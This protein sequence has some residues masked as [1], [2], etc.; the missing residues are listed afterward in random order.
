MTTCV[1]YDGKHQEQSTKDLV[2]HH[3]LH[4][5]IKIMNASLKARAESGA[6]N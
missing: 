2:M 4:I 3:G 1:S 6:A 5:D